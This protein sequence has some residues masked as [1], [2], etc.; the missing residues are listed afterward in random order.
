MNR[1]GW[2]LVIVAATALALVSLASNVTTLSQLEGKADTLLAGRLTLSQLVNA[3][4]VWAGLAV[5]SGWLVR[6]PA[7]AVAAG[8]VALL[9]ACVV[10]YGMGLAFGM[11][12]PD[13]WTANLYWLLAA[14]V[15]GGPLGLVGAIA[16]R[17]DWWGIAAR[18]VVP[19]GAVLEPFVLGRFTTPAILPWPNHMANAISGLALL[20]VGVVGCF[21]VLVANRRRQAT[22]GRPA[23]A[24]S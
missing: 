16:R 14:M 12:D 17:L 5:I 8:I 11:F 18:L 15:M 23:T 1:R 4:T 24:E 10:H 7:S 20:T 2:S 6:R 13:V 22:H 3:G 9:T 19:I 21:Y